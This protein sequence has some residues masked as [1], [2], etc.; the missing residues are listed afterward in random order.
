M[1]DKNYVQNY[2]NM[3]NEALTQVQASEIQAKIC[4]I[5]SKEIPDIEDDLE[6]SESTKAILSYDAYTTPTNYIK[7]LS[8][9]KDKLERYLVECD[10]IEIE[11]ARKLEIARASNGSFNI[12]QNQNNTQSQNVNISVTIEQVFESIKQIPEEVLQQ[13][14]KD[15]LEDKISAV[16]TAKATKDKG[17]LAS[18]IGAV[19]KYIADKGVEVGIAVLPYL[20][21][22]AKLHGQL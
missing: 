4:R 2:I 17:K 21:D 8:M 14:E 11:N 12:T 9:V 20:G 1:L 13:D 6:W 18:K 7:N 22:I 16:E 15:E 19:L 5:F 3:C 10:A